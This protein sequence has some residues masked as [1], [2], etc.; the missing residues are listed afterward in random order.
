MRTDCPMHKQT[1]PC[2][3]C[4]HVDAARSELGLPL[5]RFCDVGGGIG[6]GLR[7]ACKCIHCGKLF[8]SRSHDLADVEFVCKGDCGCT[9]SPPN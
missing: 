5:D 4:A 3:P 7:I 8:V 1:L 2:V 6:P 9:N